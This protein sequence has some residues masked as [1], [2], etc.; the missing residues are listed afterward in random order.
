MII[1]T[2]YTPEYQEMAS[3][4]ANQCKRF[5]YQHYTF[6]TT[7]KECM[8]KQSETMQS[9]ARHKPSLFLQM[10]SR[11]PNNTGLFLY[12]DADCIPVSNISELD[13]HTYNLLFTY[14]I[15]GDITTGDTKWLGVINAGVIGCYL[16]ERTQSFIKR[17]K[18]NM[19]VFESDQQA[20]N[21]MLFN[22][23]AQNW[24]TQSPYVFNASKIIPDKEFDI[25]TKMVPASIYNY[26]FIG[27]PDSAKILH[28]K[29]HARPLFSKYRDLLTKSR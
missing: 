25:C 5:G 24:S 27:P 7:K 11:F 21:S 18:K 2:S 3:L 23:P 13:D 28:F 10:F 17:W 4:Q 6:A 16:N 8:G 29:G 19:D 15:N 12:M 22:N 14:R 26:Y 20:L 1:F 9:T